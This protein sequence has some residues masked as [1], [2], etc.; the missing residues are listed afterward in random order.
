MKYPKLGNNQINLLSKLSDVFVRVKPFGDICGLF[1]IRDID[2]GAVVFELTEEQAKETLVPTELVYAA[3][4]CDEIKS[5]V[6]D[7]YE[8]RK[9]YVVMDS[10]GLNTI[11]LMYFINH[12]MKSNI[13]FKGRKI[14]AKRLIKKGEQIFANYFNRSYVHF[15]FLKGDRP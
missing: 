7:F 10:G 8:H 6:H 1:A 2:K 4:P 11:T 13:L 9:N 5:M 3:C 15:D 12:S 14:V